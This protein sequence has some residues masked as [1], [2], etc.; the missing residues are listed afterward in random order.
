MHAVKPAMMATAAVL[1]LSIGM[2]GVSFAGPMTTQP[3]TP[4]ATEQSSTMMQ[5]PQAQMPEFPQPTKEHQWL[6]QLQGQWRTE[7]EMTMMPGQP[8]VKTTGTETV[9]TVGG[10]WI[11]DAHKGEM[12]GQPFEGEMT[13]GYDRAKEQFVGTWVDSM[14][15]QLWEYEGQLSDDGK[16]LT[17]RAEGM[18]PVRGKMTEF[19]DTVELLS[20]DHK[21]YTS[22]IK[23]DD[24]Q[25]QTH[26]TSH[27][28]RISE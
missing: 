20:P 13:L 26:M 19:K 5:T 25:W 18:C 10:F 12:M 23:G 4:T 15:G 28:Y 24:G 11:K 17:L 3:E 16:Q 22:Q 27:S 2:A 9:S 21:V 8:P 1:A 7:N 14:T 6:Q